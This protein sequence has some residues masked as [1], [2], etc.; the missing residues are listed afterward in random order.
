M[1][2]I[3]IL[4][5]GAFFFFFYYNILI[6]RKNRVQIDRLQIDTM[7][8]LRAD[9]LQQIREAGGRASAN[10]QSA[11]AEVDQSLKE[12]RQAYNTGVANYNGALEQF[13]TNIFAILLR[14]QRAKP[15]EIEIP[16]EN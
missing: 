7:L 10:L 5:V 13:P 12:L 3:I 8:K 16:T 14:L 1:V 9:V 15:F 11:L 4:L 6:S 2:G